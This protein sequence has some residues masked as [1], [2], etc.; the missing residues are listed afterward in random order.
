MRN[1]LKAALAGMMFNLAGGK[2]RHFWVLDCLCLT[3]RLKEVVAS[4][5]V[6][7]ATGNQTG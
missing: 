6:A 1:V 7:M 3:R 2:G 5:S 4:A